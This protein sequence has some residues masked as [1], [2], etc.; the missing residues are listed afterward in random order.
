MNKALISHLEPLLSHSRP[1]RIHI[2]STGAGAGLLDLIWS[3]PGCSSF[4]MSYSFPYAP[5][6]TED[7]LGFKP[8]KFCSPET[9]LD[10]AMAAYMKACPSLEEGISPESVDVIGLGITASVASSRAH[11]GDHRVHLAVMTSEHVLAADL[12]LEKGVGVDARAFDGEQTDMAGLNMLLTALGRPVVHDSRFQD[13][14]PVDRTQQALERFFLRP[15]FSPTGR[16]R[17]ELGEGFMIFPGSFLP[18]H[19]GHFQ[20][21][22]AAVAES[23]L[24]VPRGEV[25]NTTFCITADPPHKDPLSLADLLARAKLLKGHDC[26]FTRGDH[27]YIE[28]AR[29]LPPGQKFI[30]GA[31][32]VLR[33]LDPKWGPKVGPMLEEFKQ[34]RTTF[35]V[36]GRQ[37]D[38]KFTTM[39]EIWQQVPA[40]YDL[41]CFHSVRGRWDVSSTEARKS[42]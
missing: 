29:K 26:Y 34:L 10:L 38:G 12:T 42:W 17:A 23:V 15:C 8:E 35:L 21:A 19:E 31:D 37:I 39:S 40:S 18:P 28:K 22:K 2:V 30:I 24:Y 9:A 32:T 7:F 20:M 1:L 4:L 27:L 41:S 25:H 14:L 5:G 36:F 6:D 11:R 16:R 33:M 3:L 13:M